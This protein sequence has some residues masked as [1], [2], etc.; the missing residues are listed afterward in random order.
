M[1]TKQ[2]LNKEN[3]NRWTIYTLLKEDSA[4]SVSEEKSEEKASDKKNDKKT[5]VTDNV[6]DNMFLKLTDRPKKIC[7]LLTK[8]SIPG[9]FVSLTFLQHLVGRRFGSKFKAN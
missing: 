9:T 1:V 5:D 6:T 3:K 4:D 2:L 7:V 8:D